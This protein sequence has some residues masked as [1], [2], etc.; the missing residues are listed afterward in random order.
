MGQRWYVDG[1]CSI[2]ALKT[3]LYDIQSNRE[4][5]FLVVFRYHRLMTSSCLAKLANVVYYFN[6]SLCLVIIGNSSQ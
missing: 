6:C 1:L 2:A 4:T 5:D 3:H